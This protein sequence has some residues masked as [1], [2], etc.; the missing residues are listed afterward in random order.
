MSEMEKEKKKTKPVGVGDV[1]TG[2]LKWPAILSPAIKTEIKQIME[3]MYRNVF[4]QES[5]LE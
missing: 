3:R 1:G 2:Q 4:R 5:S